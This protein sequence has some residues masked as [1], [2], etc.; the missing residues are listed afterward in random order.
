MKGY[1]TLYY[2]LFVLLIM[3]A[4]ASMAQNSYGLKILGG[5]AI[6]F[7]VLFLIQFIA[8]LTEKRKKDGYSP[9]ESGCLFILALIFALRVFYINFSYVELIFGLTTLIL[10]LLYF[11]KM[12]NNFS[13]LKPKNNFL[14][15]L[16]VVF[17]LAIIL[18]FISLGSITFLP[19]LSETAGIFAFAFLTGFL[20]AGLINRNFLIQG[21]KISAFK[22]VSRLKDNSILII[23]LFLLFTFYRGFTITKILPKVY[24]D[25]FPQT[26]FELV[27]KAESGKENLVNG[28]YKYQEFKEKYDEFIEQSK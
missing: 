12:M 25:E 3:G 8:S 27:N 28:K 21:E 19:K 10:I 24:S 22:F 13:F 18:Y 5:V 4:F 26:Y 23:A 15:V 6:A 1:N 16:I 9:I 11:R 14:S 20:L 7:A 17:Y 2:L